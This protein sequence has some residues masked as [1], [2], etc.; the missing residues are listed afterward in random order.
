MR[1]RCG[2]FTAWAAVSLLRGWVRLQLFPV[3]V[4]HWQPAVVWGPGAL[5]PHRDPAACSLGHLRLVWSVGGRSPS[6]PPAPLLSPLTHPS[7]LS[8][9]SSPATPLGVRAIGPLRAC[10]HMCGGLLTAVAPTSSCSEVPAFPGHVRGPAGAWGRAPAQRR[11]RCPN[12]AATN[13]SRGGAHGDQVTPG[14]PR[15]HWP[16][17]RP[18][19]RDGLP[20]V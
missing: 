19:L 17:L 12:A 3:C 8:P 13:R 7:F 2:C 5:G 11:C 18:K 9:C 20:H 14:G 1:M 4:G 15:H 6:P 16:G 10:A